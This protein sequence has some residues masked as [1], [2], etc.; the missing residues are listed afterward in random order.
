[1]EDKSILKRALLVF[2]GTLLILLIIFLFAKYNENRV[3]QEGKDTEGI[4]ISSYIDNK[5]SII[6]KVKYYVKGKEY[7]IESLLK[8]F[9]RKNRLSLPNGSVVIVKYLE[10]E[11]NYGLVDFNKDIMLPDSTFINVF[12][13][14]E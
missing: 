7:M 4:V 8:G 2:A 14:K 12:K 1:M 6:I 3:F 5:S 11:P 13:M 9:L 10:E